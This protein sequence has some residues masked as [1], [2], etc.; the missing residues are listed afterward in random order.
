MNN[1]DHELSDLAA[2]RPQ[3]VKREH[4]LR[5]F[6]LVDRQITQK[7]LAK[8]TGL[9]E[10]LISQ[11]MKCRINLDD[12]EEA[13]L[14]ALRDK[15]LAWEAKAGRLWNSPAPAGPRPDFYGK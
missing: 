1:L 7:Q 9:S 3:A 14:I 10:P 13:L 8:H 5:Q 15:L 4:P 2:R 6:F 12:D 11:A